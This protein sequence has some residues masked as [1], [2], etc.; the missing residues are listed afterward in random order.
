MLHGG[1]KVLYKSAGG[2]TMSLLCLTLLIMPGITA[3]NG[4]A[5][6]QPKSVLRT[7]SFDKDPGWEAHNNRIVPERVPTV[8]LQQNEFRRQGGGRA[9]GAGHQGGGAGVLWQTRWQSG[10]VILAAGAAH[11]VLNTRWNQVP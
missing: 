7:E 1:K 2:S 8:R 4:R 9:G 10:K 5:A 11:L 3:G 6:D